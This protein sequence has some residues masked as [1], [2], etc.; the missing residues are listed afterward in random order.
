MSAGRSLRLKVRPASKP[1]EVL[2]DT[3]NRGAGS[4]RRDAG[5]MKKQLQMLVL[6][7]L[8]LFAL[9]RT[10][11]ACD[12][13]RGRVLPPAQ[14]GPS[15]VVFLGRVARSQPLVYVEFE[16]LEAF[17]G[18]VDRRVRVLTGRSDCDYFLPPVVTKSGTRFLVFGTIHDDGILEVNRCLG[19]GPLNQKTR[20]LEI[21]RQRARPRPQ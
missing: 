7:V 11:H 13:V 1:P 14:F 18:R 8:G 9:P 3:L 10:A 17:N 19:S 2:A 12:C 21:L 16:V 4:R 15:D 20:E 5:V 6:S